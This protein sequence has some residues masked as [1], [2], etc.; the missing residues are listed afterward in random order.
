M[1]YEKVVV[2]LVS[3]D[4]DALP[5]GLQTFLGQGYD[6]LSVFLCSTA[7]KTTH[8]GTTRTPQ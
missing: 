8:V 3:M 4:L 1:A 6:E 5:E 2:E 7:R